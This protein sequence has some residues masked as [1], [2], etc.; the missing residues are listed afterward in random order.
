MHSVKDGYNWSKYACKL[1]QTSIL[2]MLICSIS[3]GHFPSLERRGT[4][5]R[6][7]RNCKGVPQPH[8]LLAEGNE[9]THQRAPCCSTL[10][11]APFRQ[12]LQQC[13]R[14]RH[15]SLRPHLAAKTR[16]PIQPRH[17]AYRPP[18]R[19]KPTRHT[20]HGQ[21]INFLWPT[22]RQIGESR[23]KSTA[24]NERSKPLMVNEKTHP[25]SRQ[26][27][28]LITALNYLMITSLKTN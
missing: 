9:N 20:I 22:I 4:N 17:V 19:M 27:E 6:C 5:W 2:R 21:P 18:S 3:T 23:N 14:Y 16:Q 13:M 11:N 15:H 7:Q 8:C 24:I 10:L 26:Y 1:E 28:Y 25:S 12:H